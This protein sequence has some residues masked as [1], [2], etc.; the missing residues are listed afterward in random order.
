MKGSLAAFAVLASVTLLAVGRATAWA[1]APRTGE[2]SV[3]ASLDHPRAY[4]TAVTLPNG[5]ILV[6]GGLDQN[7]PQLVNPTSELIDPATARVTTLPG[8]VPG[9]LH[10]TATV[11]EDRVVAAGGVEWTGGRFGSTDHVKV[12][13]P[14]AG[15]WIAAAPLLQGRSDHGAAALGGGRVLVTGGNFNARPLAS[16]EIYDVGA[17][18]WRTAAPLSHPRVRFSIAPLPD[19]RVLVAGGLD[20]TGHPLA[21][22]EIYDPRADRWTPGP[23]MSVARVQ[24]TSVALP[25]GDVLFIGGQ[26][27]A[28]GTAER[29]DHR[30]GTF[31]WAGSLITPRLVAQAAVLPDGR[32]LVTGGSPERPGRTDWVPFPDAEV[33]DPRTDLWSAFPSPAMP[34]AL[35]QLVPTP[36]GLFLIS[37]I[38]TDQAAEGTIEHLTLR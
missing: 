27:G 16:S 26:N 37:G 32:V 25:G 8:H 35:G 30:S 12:F 2:W 36:W 34:R 23:D 11:A 13:L 14:E 4:A 28:S 6:F 3:A 18:L 21:S 10:L 1:P 15:R 33:W 22:S 9:R 38:G 20:E 17:D 7:D 29:Y 19:G 5:K 31:A 24:H